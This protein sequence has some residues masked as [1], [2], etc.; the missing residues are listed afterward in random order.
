MADFRDT[1][2]TPGGVARWTGI[3][4]LAFLIAALIT[5]YFLDWNL[6]RG[7]IGRYASAKSGREVR[8]DGNLKGHRS[9]MRSS[10]SALCPPSSAI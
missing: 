3:V 10:N 2:I 8:I 4:I 6:L 1:R 5:L 7:P 9:N